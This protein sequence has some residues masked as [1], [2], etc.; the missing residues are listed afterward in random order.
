[1]EHKFYTTNADSLMNGQLIL[2][3]QT[4]HRFLYLTFLNIHR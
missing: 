4:F 1:M 3:I 2:V